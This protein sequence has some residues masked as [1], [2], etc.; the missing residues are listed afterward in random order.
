V[1]LGVRRAWVPVFAADDVE[2]AVAVDVEDACGLE[3]FVAHLKTGEAEGHG[4]LLNGF[5]L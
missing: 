4:E 5:Y 1:T 3:R 2:N